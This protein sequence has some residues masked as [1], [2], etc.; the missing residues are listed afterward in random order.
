MKRLIFPA[1]ILMT[2]VFAFGDVTIDQ[3]IENA[4]RSM[5][6]NLPA[7]TQIVVVDFE[8][9][10]D[11][12]NR[13]NTQLSSYV[14]ERLEASFVNGR[15]LSVIA[16][17]RLRTVQGERYYQNSGNVSD[18]EAA[19]MGRELGAGIVITGRLRKIND[20][21]QFNIYAIA[22][23]SAKIEAVFETG[24]RLDATLSG[25]LG[26]TRQRELQQAAEAAQREQNEQAARLERE[27]NR[28]RRDKK[29]VLG[30][31]GAFDVSFT[32][33]SE[34]FFG[35]GATKDDAFFETFA[36]SGYFGLNSVSSAMGFRIEGAYIHNN[37]I[38]V[39]AGPG[40]PGGEYSWNSLDGA[41]LFNFGYAEGTLFSLYAGPYVSFPLSDLSG[42]QSGDIEKSIFVIFSSWGLLGG[43]KAGL[44]AGP[45]YVVLDGRFFYDL[46]ETKV[47]VGAAADTNFVR[48]MGILIGVGYEFWL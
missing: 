28:A 29:I 9:A 25:L 44:K 27:R 48:R 23:E 45:G 26:I 5:E 33:P 4:R 42:S 3:A 1:L 18:L 46:N 12:Y 40:G 21:Y 19:R 6:S 41:L 24:V 36:F 39:S 34:D 2:A 37:A 13:S 16:R 31:Q 20:N 7:Q 8:D 14:T 11:P 30:V 47:T 10:T 43:L 15:K 32:E 22:V 17:S 35:P 38:S